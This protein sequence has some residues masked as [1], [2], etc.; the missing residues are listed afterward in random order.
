VSYTLEITE[1]EAMV[2]FEFFARFD[3]TNE[4]QFDHAAEYVALLRLSA[5]I[6]KTTPAVFSPDFASQLAAARE[7]IAEGFEGAVPAR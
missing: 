2:L 7:R 5:Q 1:D 6:D 4:L 3:D